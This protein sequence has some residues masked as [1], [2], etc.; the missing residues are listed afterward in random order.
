MCHLVSFLYQHA[1]PLHGVERQYLLRAPG[2]LYE[3]LE[4]ITWS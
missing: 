1:N 3:L 2:M 4:S